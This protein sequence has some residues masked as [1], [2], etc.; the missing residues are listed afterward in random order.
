MRDYLWDFHKARWFLLCWTSAT[1][2]KQSAMNLKSQS[3]P[4][5]WKDSVAIA[6]MLLLLWFPKIMFCHCMLNAPVCTRRS[7]P[8]PGVQGSH[9]KWLLSQVNT[10]SYLIRKGICSKNLGRIHFYRS[11][12]TGTYSSFLHKTRATSKFRGSSSLW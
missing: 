12:F 7:R 10:D 4:F 8:N 6:M 2:W 11:Y 9:L 3:F 5:F 1:M